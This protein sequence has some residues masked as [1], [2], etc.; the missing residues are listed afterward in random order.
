[1]AGARPGRRRPS[2]R[3]EEHADHRRALGAAGEALVA[4][5]YEANGYEVVDTNWRCRDGELDLVLAAP[6]VLVFCE[7]KT[8][9]SRAFV[10]PYEAVTPAKQ[11]RIRRL[12]VRWLGERGVRARTIRFDVASVVH[13]RGAEPSVDV[14]EAAF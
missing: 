8:R 14:I 4:R 13:E 1:V 3:G 9:R 12:A 6:G 2:R 10:A 5:W 7:V 11:R